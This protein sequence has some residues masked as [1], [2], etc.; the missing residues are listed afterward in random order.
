KRVDLQPPMQQFLQEPD[1][2]DAL[3]LTRTLQQ[4]RYYAKF[5]MLSDAKLFLED[6]APVFRSGSAISADTLTALQKQ[7]LSQLPVVAEL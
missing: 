1:D 2:E 5:R 7:T 4:S 6:E 3:P